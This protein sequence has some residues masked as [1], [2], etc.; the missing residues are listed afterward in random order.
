MG[1]LCCSRRATANGVS[2][3]DPKL[4]NGTTQRL[5]HDT[6]ALAKSVDGQ[7]RFPIGTRVECNCAGWHAGTVVAHWWRD[8]SW[9]AGKVV[10][11]QVKVDNGPTIF[12]PMD[13]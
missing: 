7:L 2:E 10:P 12:V 13:Q 6:Q 9:P 1:G 4:E 11:Y 8:A 3:P 5:E